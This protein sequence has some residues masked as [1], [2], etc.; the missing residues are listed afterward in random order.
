MGKNKNTNIAP[1]AMK[2]NTNIKTRADSTTNSNTTTSASRATNRQQA[3]P[4]VV[5]PPR[6]ASAVGSAGVSSSSNQPRNRPKRGRPRKDSGPTKPWVIALPAPRALA[7]LP[8]LYQPPVDSQA[9][10]AP[11]TSQAPPA[12]P[13]SPIPPAPLFN[14]PQT[15][16]AKKDASAP[17]MVSSREPLVPVGP[18]SLP[19]EVYATK[20]NPNPAH[21][22]PWTP[23]PQSL[24][25]FAPPVPKV[26]APT[27]S[28]NTE[29]LAP[30]MSFFL[31]PPTTMSPLPSGLES[32][33]AKPEGP[34][35]ALD[36]DWVRKRGQSE[37]ECKNIGTPTIEFLSHAITVSIGEG[38]YDIVG[39]NGAYIMTEINDHT[40]RVG[41]LKV[42]LANMK[43]TLFGGEV[44]GP[45]IAASTVQLVLG[46][47][48]WVEGNFSEGNNP[49]I[50]GDVAVP[51][52]VAAYIVPTNAAATT[53]I[54]AAT[55]G[56][57]ARGS[58][59]GAGGVS[60]STVDDGVGSTDGTAGA[61]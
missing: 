43:G 58:A 47:Y 12:S 48:L 34:S 46:T 56:G 23:A 32:P 57:G 35:A 30:P 14:A 37:A 40:H 33:Q 50:I 21:T 2:A 20:V 51:A 25:H 7:G 41:G 3:N 28:P 26:S 54:V 6:S 44:A 42:T 1:T 38:S 22:A 11:P 36:E 8:P 59:S 49:I 9:P 27:M 10:T 17:L 15:R 52:V 60:V 39:L 53:V 18:A 16:A 31:E 19:Q 4:P 24:V 61:E 55:G 5:P 13:S 29:T 45:L